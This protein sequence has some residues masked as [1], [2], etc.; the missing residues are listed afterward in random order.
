[1]IT[2]DKAGY[3]RS[4]IVVPF[5]VFGT[6]RGIMHDAGIANPS[7]MPIPGLI[8]ISMRRKS[9]PQFG[10]GRNQKGWVHVEDGKHEL[11]ESRFTHASASGLPF[12]TRSKLIL[13][14][15]LVASLFDTILLR[16]PADHGPEG[17]F[18]CVS[19]EME[20]VSVTTA[21]AEAFHDA[22]IFEHAQAVPVAESDLEGGWVSPRIVYQPHNNDGN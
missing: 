22:G 9:V 20:A 10:E 13:Y 14:I 12:M 17:I 2:A 18:F 5:A 19:D 8:D 15:K 4:F 3:V 7:S 6:A 1:M 21:L 16:Q 11:P